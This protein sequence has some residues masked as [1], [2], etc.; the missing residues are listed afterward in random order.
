MDTDEHGYESSGAPRT[1]INYLRVSGLQVYLLLDF[2]NLRLEV[3]R[4]VL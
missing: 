1:C 3:T 4:F 2:G